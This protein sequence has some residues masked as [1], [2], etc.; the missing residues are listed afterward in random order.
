MVCKKIHDAVGSQVR[1]LLLFWSQSTQTAKLLRGVGGRRQCTV[2]VD[3]GVVRANVAELRDSALPALVRGALARGARAG[4]RVISA[5]RVLVS[6]HL[7]VLTCVRAKLAARA[8]RRG[9]VRCLRTSEHA[10][11]LVPRLILLPP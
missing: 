1:C 7:Y 8:L 9:A 3:A 2:P 4:A 6:R 10:T 11:C 5:E